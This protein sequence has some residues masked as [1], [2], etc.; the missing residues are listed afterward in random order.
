MTEHSQIEAL[1]ALYWAFIG[2]VAAINYLTGWH[3]L[4][5][6]LGLTGS[7][8]TLF[9]LIWFVTVIRGLPKHWEVAFG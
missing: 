3:A 8:L 5:D 7:S 4:Q 2:T 6:G 9:Y 1:L